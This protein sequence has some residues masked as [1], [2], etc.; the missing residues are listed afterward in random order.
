VRG[1]FTEAYHER[2]RLG[3]DL[4]AMTRAVRDKLLEQRAMPVYV[5]RARLSRPDYRRPRLCVVLGELQRDLILDPAATLTQNDVMDL[6]H[7]A[8]PSMGCDFLLLDCP[9]VNRVETMGRRARDNGFDLP[10]AQ[11][12]SKRNN[13]LL[14]FL[15][16]LKQF[17]M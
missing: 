9:W 11:C 2:E 15:D 3:P 10:L 4:D 8:L 12:F 16:A 13:G 5:E 7:A 6:L 1:L 14:R 17:G